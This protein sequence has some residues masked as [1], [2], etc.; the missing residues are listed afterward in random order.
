MKNKRGFVDLGLFLTIIGSL[1]VATAGYRSKSRLEDKKIEKAERNEK[2]RILNQEQSIIEA[3][4]M[5]EFN[6]SKKEHERGYIISRINYEGAYGVY[7]SDI[8][9]VIEHLREFIK[10]RDRRFTGYSW[11][12]EDL[13]Y[14]QEVQ[15]SSMNKAAEALIQIADNIYRNI[16][17]EPF[18]ILKVQGIEKAARLYTAAIEID[19]THTQATEKLKRAAAKLEEIADT[20]YEKGYRNGVLRPDSQAIE[21]AARLY[22]VAAQFGA[23]QAARKLEGIDLDKVFVSPSSSPSW[24][25]S[26]AGGHC[27]AALAGV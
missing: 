5:E 8:N 6:V 14:V 26:T 11:T 27:Q 25:F 21:E 13:E 7:L 16:V 22:A 17:W 23:T 19:H 3:V 9:N 1:A 18:T 10:Y 15:E 20:F 12:R 2:R 24:E 4:L